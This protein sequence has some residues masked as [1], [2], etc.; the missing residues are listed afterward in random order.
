[1]GQIWKL[2]LVRVPSLENS[3]EL[4][5]E[6]RHRPHNASSRRGS[7]QPPDASL[8]FHQETDMLVSAVEPSADG[9]LTHRDAWEPKWSQ[10]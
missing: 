7:S 4:P 3:N 6:A 10:L 9:V 5:S 2:A 8:S 1:M